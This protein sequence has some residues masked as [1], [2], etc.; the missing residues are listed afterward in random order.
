[1]A[2]PDPDADRQDAK[3]PSETGETE[4]GTVRSDSE[5]ASN[6]MISD[7]TRIGPYLAQIR[8]SKNLT[9]AELS[10]E[11]RITTR[12]LNAIES[13]QIGPIPK[14]YLTV[15][16]RAYASRLGLDAADIVSRYTRQCGAVSE[17]VKPKP[18]VA[19][20]PKGSSIFWP[21]MA[22]LVFVIGLVAVGGYAY[23]V[24]G[25]P[26][27]PPIVTAAEPVNGARES[28]FAEA[29]TPAQ[30]PETLPLTLYAVSQSWIEVRGSDGT[31]FRE[32]VMVAGETYFPRVGAGWTI[33]AADGGAFEWRVGDVVIGPLGP[34]GAPVYTLSVDSTAATAAETAAP[35]LASNRLDANRP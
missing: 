10:E 2:R 20:A 25:E 21:A 17:V 29:P 26:D 24:M 16:L 19:P 33:S 7:D 14:G 6:D 23:G 5:I 8:E 30:T 34:A 27:A 3:R 13:M 28:L 31:V 22:G 11:L 1:M 32:R 15:Y 35:A 4:G 9:I 18:I 12:Y